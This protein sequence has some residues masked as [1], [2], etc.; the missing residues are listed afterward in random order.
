MPQSFFITTTR[1]DTSPLRRNAA[2]DDHA[3]ELAYVVRDPV[4][5][6]ELEDE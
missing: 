1:R 5:R 2:G 3:Q 6:H 4:D